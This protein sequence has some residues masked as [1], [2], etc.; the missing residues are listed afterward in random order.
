METI[1]FNEIT[2]VEPR[3]NF[4]ELRIPKLITSKS[5]TLY[6]CTFPKKKFKIYKRN[7]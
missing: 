7:Y 5:S 3:L 1:I 4:F 2:A 6:M